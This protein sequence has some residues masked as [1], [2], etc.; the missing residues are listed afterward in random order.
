VKR[1]IRASTD[2]LDKGPRTAAPV[3]VRRVDPLAWQAAKA[4]AGGDVR[5]LQIVDEQTVI[6]RN[7]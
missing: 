5:R 2:R 1:K 3:Q 4:K 6:I 7:P